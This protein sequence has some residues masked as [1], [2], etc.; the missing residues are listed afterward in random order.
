MAT[1][2]IDGAETAIEWVRDDMVDPFWGLVKNDRYRRFAARERPN[3]DVCNL[4]FGVS[5]IS[6]RKILSK[7][8]GLNGSGDF[9]LRSAVSRQRGSD[10]I[11]PDFSTKLQIAAA[12]RTR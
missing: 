8:V 3:D 12:V 6:P 5:V 1:E 7:S 4:G 11:S 9:T 2:R 10:D